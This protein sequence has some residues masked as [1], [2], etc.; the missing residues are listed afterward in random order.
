MT[1][2]AAVEAARAVGYNG[3]NPETIAKLILDLTDVL[4]NSNTMNEPEIATM[5]RAIADKVAPIEHPA[6]K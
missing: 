5:L 2:H 6:V 3:K 1:P 4:Y